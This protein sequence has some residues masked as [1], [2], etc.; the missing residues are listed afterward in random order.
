MN[1]LQRMHN[2]TECATLQ[3]LGHNLTEC[4]TA[5]DIDLTL[6]KFHVK[7]TQKIV[8]TVLK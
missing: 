4:A 7:I 5:I 6:V 3:T 1:V 2:L 8:E